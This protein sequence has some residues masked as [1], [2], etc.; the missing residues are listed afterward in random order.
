MKQIKL[1]AVTQSAVTSQVKQPDVLSIA[2]EQAKKDTEGIRIAKGGGKVTGDEKS[3]GG[4]LLKPEEAR[5]RGIPVPTGQ[6]VV[7]VP[8]S[9]LNVKPIVTGAETPG[10]LAGDIYKVL[11]PET[12]KREISAGAK[13]F[14]EDVSKVLK[15]VTGKSIGELSERNKAFFSGTPERR[16][17][18]EILQFLS[19]GA[20]STSAGK[21][22]STL[23]KTVFAKQT[24]VIHGKKEVFR[25]QEYRIGDKNIFAR[26]TQTTPTKYEIISPFKK[27]LGF[28]PKVSYSS[29]YRKIYLETTTKFTKV[30]EPY[31]L[32]KTRWPASRP[33]N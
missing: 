9:Q 16:E 25:T 28:K 30:G 10:E 23:P 20:M 13:R 3:M 32:T 22:T 33:S 18:T 19:L 8:A 11:A 31:L 27:K 24:K 17:A 29:K 26:I 7:S 1:A 2:I 4:I 14:G 15:K 6:Q 12:L 21:L 5:A